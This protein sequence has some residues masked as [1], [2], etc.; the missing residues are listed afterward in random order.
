MP[1]SKGASRGA[2]RPDTREKKHSFSFSNFTG[3][4]GSSARLTS[5]DTDSDTPRNE[6]RAYAGPSPR[7]SSPRPLLY[8][9]FAP[10]I[11]FRRFGTLLKDK[12]KL[13]S[14][15]LFRLEDEVGRY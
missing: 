6:S 13:L 11:Q 2:A 3:A 4:K 10:L 8:R 1:T 14:D 9:V 15:N 7:L 12:E 5:C